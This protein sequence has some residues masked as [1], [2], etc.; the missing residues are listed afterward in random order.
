MEGTIPAID[1]TT[2]AERMQDPQQS[3]AVF[4][5]I[6]EYIKKSEEMLAQ[7]NKT[8]ET[9]VNNAT[10]TSKKLIDYAKAMAV[11]QS[12]IVTQQTEPG[13]KDMEDYVM[14]HAS[15]EDVALIMLG[16]KEVPNFDS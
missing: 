8:A 5:E 1:I 3:G 16:K 2:L 6:S 7:A 15:W 10:E 11:N 14:N 12:S 13:P 4:A 9:A